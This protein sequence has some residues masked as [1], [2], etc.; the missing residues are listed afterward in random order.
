M[1]TLTEYGRRAYG[2]QRRITP[3][4]QARFIADSIRLHW[5]EGLKPALAD[6]TDDETLKDAVMALLIRKEAQS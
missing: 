4:Q 2:P 5:A 1:V 3:Q 6:Y